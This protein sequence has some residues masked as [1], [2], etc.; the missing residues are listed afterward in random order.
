[1]SNAKSDAKEFHSDVLIVGGGLNGLTMALAAASGGFEVTLVD[2]LDPAQALDAGFDGRVFAIAFATCRMYGALGLWDELKTDAQ[3]INDIVV[4]DGTV[5]GGASPLF[6]HF[7]HEEIGDEPLGHLMESRHMRAVLTRA[8]QENPKIDFRAPAK[9]VDKK[10]DAYGFSVTLED[11]ETLRAPL[12][13]ACD[14]RGSPLRKFAKIKTVGWSYKQVGIVTTVEHEDDHLGVAQEFF[15]PGGPFAI[16]PM[17]GRRASLVWTEG[18]KAGAALMALP[19]ERF[20]EELRQR[21]G[22]YLGAVKTVGPV[23]SYPLTLQLAREYVGDRLALIGDAAH[24]IHPIAGQGLNLGLRDVAVM[25]EV[26][27]DAARLGEDIGSPLVLERY[28]QARRFDNVASSL[29]MDGLNRLFS[30]DIAP[31]RLAR[32]LGLAAVNKLGPAR[33]FFMRQ[34]GGDVGELPKLLRGERL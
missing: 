27:C 17:T 3:P 25:A 23:W 30:N 24:G 4:T 32:D 12:V 15:L 9:V 16:L 1:V 7:D 33:R 11:G 20:E 18:T 28:Q 8:V 13:L 5:R 6:L 21:F 29:A 26:L 31:V 34:A 2:A 22:D 14:G 10:A 19:K